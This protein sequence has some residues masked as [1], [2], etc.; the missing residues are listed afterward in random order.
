MAAA[1]ESRNIARQR[2]SL[3]GRSPLIASPGFRWGFSSSS[4]R[5]AKPPPDLAIIYG[6]WAGAVAPAA[7]RLAGVRHSIYS[8]QWP[9]FYT[10]WDL[11]RVIRNWISEAIPCRSC[12]R[13]VPLSRGSWYQYSIRRLG[14]GKLRIIHNCVDLNRVPTAEKIRALR[15][16]QWWKEEQ[17]H[18]VSIG[19]L[20]DQKR[21]DW[22]LRSWRIVQERRTNARLWIVGSGPEEAALHRLAEELD[23]GG[24]C[25]FLGAR[26]NGIEYAA[27]ADIVAMTTL[28]EGH[29]IGALEALACGRPI[30]VNDVDGTDDS[31][32]DGVEGFLV[33]P[34]EIE[35]FA[36]KLLLLV[37]DADLRKRMGEAGRLRAQE[38]SVTRISEQYL[39]LIAEVLAEG[40]AGAPK[41]KP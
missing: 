12:D 18:V 26:P 35:L 32:D 28:Y 2:G 1:A 36:E 38:F 27:A 41:I 25:T 30:V 22:L 19:R 29:S 37:E 40:A 24:T 11:R 3:T 17:C 33:P 9:S 15:D 8:C 39:S 34:A 4:E 13:V 5:S 21:V 20:A 16:A 31:I 7:L 14:E 6:Q 23:I 10:D